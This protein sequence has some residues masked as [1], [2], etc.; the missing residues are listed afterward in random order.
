MSH[1]SFLK[2][3]IFCF[4]E[5]KNC[6]EVSNEMKVNKCWHHFYF[7][8]NCPFKLHRRNCV[9]LLNTYIQNAQTAYRNTFSGT[10][11]HLC[12]SE[13]NIVYSVVDTL[14]YWLV[15]LGCP[16]ML[17][18]TKK[19]QTYTSRVCRCGAGYLVPQ[20][21]WGSCEPMRPLSLET[22]FDLHLKPPATCSLSR[23][24]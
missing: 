18:S 7:Y 11:D 5:E 24:G 6:I 19:K 1:E 21:S 16:P 3:F 8:V 13:K 10:K 17:L 9:L 14:R 23:Y 2:I 22:D 20:T 4:T 12:T 15:Q